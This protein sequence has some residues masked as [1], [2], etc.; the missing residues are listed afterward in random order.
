MLGLYLNARNFVTNRLARE[1]KGAT[2]VEYGIVVALVAI[3]AV[4]AFALLP[5]LL[6]TLFGKVSSTVNGF[7]PS[8]TKTT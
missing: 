3:A 7:T 8:V 4:A 6:N 2:A 5:D 1:E